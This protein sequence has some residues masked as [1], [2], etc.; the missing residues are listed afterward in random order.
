[1]TDRG[2][3]FDGTYRASVTGNPKREWVFSTPPVLR[4]LIDWYESVL[5]SSASPLACSGD[6]IGSNLILYSNDWTNAAWTK[7]TTTVTTGVSDPFTATSGLAL[8]TTLSATAG[9]AAVDQTLSAGSSLIR[10]GSI[11]VK[12]RTG[13]GLIKMIRPDGAAY[14]TIAVTSTWTRFADT[15]AASTARRAGLNIVT[16]GDEI[17]V[18]GYQLEDGATASTYSQTT[19][20]ASVTN[21]IPEI[22]GW[23]PIKTGDGYRVV[24]EIILHEA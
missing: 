10:T 22:T 15:G 24:G 5:F 2:R 20:A 12:R 17:D 4:H 1:M 18:F 13:S 19:T 7:V 11:W 9:N 8:A 21:C 23:S 3:A 16:S 6:V 14:D